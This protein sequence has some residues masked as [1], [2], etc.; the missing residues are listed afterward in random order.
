[1]GKDIFFQIHENLPRE[2]PGRSK[3]TRKAFRTLP[4]LNKPRILDVCCGFGGMVVL[5]YPELSNSVLQRKLDSVKATGVDTVVTNCT[6]CVPQLRGDLDSVR[7]MS[8]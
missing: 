6:P 3:Y 5:D 4:K 8:K 1:M 7:V 2:G